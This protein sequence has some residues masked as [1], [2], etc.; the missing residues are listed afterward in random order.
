MGVEIRT[1]SQTPP[2]KAKLPNSFLERLPQPRHRLII[3][4]HQVGHSKLRLL[5]SLFSM[6]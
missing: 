4:I 1:D 5:N 2:R 6:R 3:A